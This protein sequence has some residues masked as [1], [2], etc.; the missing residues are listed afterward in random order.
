MPSWSISSIRCSHY[1]VDALG[2]FVPEVRRIEIAAE[3]K[4][5]DHVGP[6][7]SFELI[8]LRRLFLAAFVDVCE[9]AG[10]LRFNQDGQMWKFYALRLNHN[11]D[12]D[13]HTFCIRPRWLHENVEP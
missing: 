11:V 3:E 13:L 1:P 12:G 8:H 6:V 5:K 10:G 2:G 7:G 9:I 4:H